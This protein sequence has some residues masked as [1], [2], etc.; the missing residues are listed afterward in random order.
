MRA[1]RGKSIYDFLKIGV[2]ESLF[3]D[4]N[5]T[6]IFVTSYNCSQF[7]GVLFF[8]VQLFRQY[9]L[10]STVRPFMGAKVAH[11]QN[12][13]GIIV[14]QFFPFEQWNLDSLKQK[15]QTAT[16]FNLR[17]LSAFCKLFY[18]FLNPKISQVRISISSPVIKK[19]TD[20]G[21]NFLF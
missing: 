11:I 10:R 21:K 13:H 12:D 5:R 15:N 20:N 19:L 6:F 2:V 8:K 7:V 18:F 17:G 14:C 16:G 9:G 4:I 3:Q 1:G